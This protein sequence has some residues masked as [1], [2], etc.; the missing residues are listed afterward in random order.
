MARVK[1]VLISWGIAALG[2]A[3]LLVVLGA[4][5]QSSGTVFEPLEQ[6][7]GAVLAGDHAKLKDLYISGPDA[8]VQT[9]AGKSGALA[10]AESDFW[11]RLQAMGLTELS[12]KILERTEPDA[13][14]VRLVLRVEMAF[15]RGSE[16][17]KSVVAAV[18]TWVKRGGTWRILVTQRSDAVP[19]HP[20]QLP[21]PAIPNTSLYP[22]PKDAREELSAALAAARMDHKRVLVVFGA[23]WCYDCH[24]LDTA[25]HTKELALLVNTNYHV[26][27]ISIGDDGKSNADLAARFQ[28]PLDKGIPSL[29][30]L[31]ANERL[32]TSQRNG[33]FE[34]AAK[35]GMADV[36]GFLNRWKPEAVH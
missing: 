22:D 27:H 13:G 19:L 12:P 10:A 17:K 2:I 28:V 25:L 14:N 16:T 24:V 21:E 15:D 32:I 5:T 3:S 26:V 34:S 1:R 7:K 4:A 18:Q 9:A 29:A 8:Y 6:W 35:I 36:G 31:D 33:E 30:V 20:I 11:L 23:N